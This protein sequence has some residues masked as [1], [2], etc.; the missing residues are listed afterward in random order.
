MCSTLRVGVVLADAE[1]ARTIA[2]GTNKT[3]IHGRTHFIV[4][5]SAAIIPAGRPP[6]S[7]APRIAV[8]T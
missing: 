8:A 7:W 4:L 5:A 2:E 1:S 3:I 6:A